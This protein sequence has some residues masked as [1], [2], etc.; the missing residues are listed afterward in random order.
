MNFAIIAAAGSGTR[1]S[2]GTNKVFLK[3]LDNPMIY[4]TLK[5]FNDS[6]HI[7]EIIVV[8]KKDD[9][10]RIEEVKKNNKFNKISKIVEGGRER[11]DS[12]FS[13]LDSIENAGEDDIILVH[14]GSNPLIQ[15]KEI[16]DVIENTKKFDAA[17]AGFALKDTI[18]KTSDG[19]IENTIDRKDVFQMQTPQGIKYGLFK[20]AYSN[21][22][23][24]N[25]TVT[26][27]VSLVEHLGKKVK[28][29]PCS[30]ENFKIT[31]REDLKIAEGILITRDGL[32]KV[33]RVGIGQDSHRFSKD[34]NKKL[35]L[36]G[37]VIPGEIGFEANSD[38][39]VI[40]HAL[41]NAISSAI[42]A[43]SLGY[44]ADPMCKKGITDSKEY[45][46]VILGKMK[47]KNLK[48]N[49]A[50]V[51]I[52]AGKPKLGQHINDIKRSLSKILKLEKDKIGITS[53][54]GEKL[55]EFGKGWGIQ[56]FVV[57]TVK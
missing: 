11:Q 31:T 54:S 49:N 8:T 26:D 24:K 18:K 29:V 55:T 16:V 51:M 35:Y 2:S 13:G 7:H 23:E 40:L 48:I 39:D 3:L 52:E 20:K 21:A 45:L 30:Y 25:L 34:S 6:K 47:K 9:I 46:K 57:I 5:T 4:Y 33:A 56:C 50:S 22:K 14:N 10:H 19:F 32:N 1:M 36:G 43:R 28:I 44:Y 53:T 42:G 15:E 12:V 41:F 37:I 17:V 27:D 38:G